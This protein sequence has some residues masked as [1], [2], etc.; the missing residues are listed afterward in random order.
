M[1]EKKYYCPDCG[2][3]LSLDEDERET[4]FEEDD[5]L[6]VESTYYCD[7]CGYP[8]MALTE[9]YKLSLIDSTTKPL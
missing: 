1:E 9:R 2:A 7:E 5:I 3:E 8:K 6:V 4:W